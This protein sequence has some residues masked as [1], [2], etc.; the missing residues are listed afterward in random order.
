MLSDFKRKTIS[1]DELKDLS[2]KYEHKEIVEL[3]EKLISSNKI[4]PIK[5]SG[6]TVNIPNIYKKY[7]IVKEANFDEDLLKEISTFYFSLSTEYYRKNLKVYIKHREH[8]KKIND[9]LI[10]KSECLKYKVSVNERSYEIFTDEKFLSSDEGKKILSNLNIDLYKFLNVYKTPEP[11]CY[12][13]L[14]NKTPQNILI[15]ENKDTFVSLM[16][17]LNEGI[18]NILTKEFTTIIYGEGYKIH[19]SFDYIYE[20]VTLRFLTNKNNKFLYWGDIDKEGFAIYSLFKDKN[21]NLNISLFKEAY[22]SMIEKSNEF[23]LGFMKKKQTKEYREVLH[24]L[25]GETQ[26]FIN[27]ILDFNKYIPQEILNSNY[28]RNRSM[29][30]CD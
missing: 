26:V 15:V 1:L 6:K 10:N 5:S 7:R 25:P 24:E 20:D 13:S 16:K 19:S 3:V 12:I 8:V 9:Y 29:I 28:L 21:V 18:N 23:E 11:F 30:N 22:Q 4:I 2:Q 17:L 14:S 27:N